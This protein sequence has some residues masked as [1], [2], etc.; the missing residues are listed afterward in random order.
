VHPITVSKWE[1][2]VLQPTAY[3]LGLIRHFG[4][5]AK[6]RP[7]TADEDLGTLLIT[8]GVIG[9]LGLLFAW[10]AD[11]YTKGGRRPRT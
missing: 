11:E 6:K 2:G 4:K 7:R 10:A 1:S 9:V 3:Q 8:I 5:A